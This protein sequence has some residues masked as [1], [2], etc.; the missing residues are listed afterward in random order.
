MLQPNQANRA[1]CSTEHNKKTS[2]QP[3]AHPIAASSDEAPPG[4]PVRAALLPTPPHLPPLLQVRPWE[5]SPLSSIQPISKRGGRCSPVSPALMSNPPTFHIYGQHT[6][7]SV[8]ISGGKG[9]EP[10]W[11]GHSQVVRVSLPPLSA[12]IVLRA[13]DPH[14][15]WGL[16]A[17]APGPA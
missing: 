11:Q 10:P 13:P 17:A 15:E 6:S 4:K 8:Q 12:L 14:R 9:A 16:A 7:V 5:E 2:D 1:M 3:K